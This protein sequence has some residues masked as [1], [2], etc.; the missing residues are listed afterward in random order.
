[1]QLDPL[2]VAPEAKLLTQ[3]STPWPGAMDTE[4]VPW[5]VPSSE[6][7]HPHVHAVAPNVGVPDNTE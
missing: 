4:S 2:T 3:V 6:V 5:Q 1:M 7:E